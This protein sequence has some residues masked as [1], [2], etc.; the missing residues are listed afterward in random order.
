MGGASGSTGSAGADG[1]TGA[2]GP[3]GGTPVDVA[4]WIP[5]P[6]G[7]AVFVSPGDVD[8]ACFVDA[9]GNVELRGHLTLFPVPAVGGS[10]LALLPEDVNGNCPC[11][12]E[13]LHIITS[14]TALAFANPANRNL[15][16]VCMV[17]LLVDHDVFPDVNEDGMINETDHQRVRG[18]P[19]FNIDASGESLCPDFTPESCGREDVNRDG[20][21]NE[22]DVTSI[23]Q[24]AP[25]GTRVRCGAVYATAFS[26]GST[27]RAPLVPAVR[28]SL[29]P[30]FYRN[31]DGL[32][33]R[34]VRSEGLRGDL[35]FMQTRF[36][37]KQLKVEMEQ[38]KVEMEHKLF[39]DE[40]QDRRCSCVRAH[41]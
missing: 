17:R 37:Q 32:M 21:V 3:G 4:E 7:R 20:K 14:T 16:E 23:L 2:T 5:M 34:A 27:R 18:S 39:A 6:S 33:A 15:A 13:G 28:I 40:R 9:L 22:L 8:P 31:D 19:Y 41:V 29:D 1:A 10:L 26:C 11:S 30:V 25:S 36:S 35:S 24:S 12:P 38:Q